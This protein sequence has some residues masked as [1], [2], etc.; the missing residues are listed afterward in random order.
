MGIFLG[1]NKIV[2]GIESNFD[3]EIKKRGII[4]NSNFN[5]LDF[6]FLMQNL[7]NLLSDNKEAVQKKSL[8]I[9]ADS[10]KTIDSKFIAE[11]NVTSSIGLAKLNADKITFD[12]KENTFFGR[13]EYFNS[14]I[15]HSS[16]DLTGKIKKVKISNCNHN[17][18]FG[19]IIGD[20]KKTEYAA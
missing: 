20:L 9:E 11:G 12:Q 19:E 15:A 5:N 3:S 17:T 13:D 14:V 8:E 4:E 10:Q 16:D 1:Q 2:Y 7:T 6:I 18:L